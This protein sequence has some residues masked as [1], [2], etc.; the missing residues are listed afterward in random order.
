MIQHK[1]HG[2]VGQTILHY[3]ILEKLGEGGMG[4][5]YRAHDTKLDRDVALKFLPKEVSSDPVEVARFNHEAKAISHLNHDHIATIFN[6]EEIEGQRFIAL[7]HIAGGTLKQRIRKEKLTIEHVIEYSIHITEGLAHAHKHGVIH[8]DLKTDNI[9][10]TEEDE[11]KITD[12][13]LAK[14]KGASK[15]TKT[16]STI[17][18]TAYMSPEQAQGEDVDNRSDL[19][20]LG[21]VLYEIASGTLPFR[22][23]HEMAILYEI[24]NIPHKPLHE[25]D[26]KIPSEFSMIVDKLLEKDIGK[27]YQSAE[28]VLNDLCSLQKPG[29]KNY[30][31]RFIRIKR[32]RKIIRIAVPLLMVAVIFGFVYIMFISNATRGEKKSIAVLPFRNIGDDKE[33][34]YFSDGIT[35]DIINH[36]LKIADLK[37]ISRTSIM[38][39]KNTTK[40]PKQIAA[41]LNVA[42]LLEGSVRKIGNQLR[43]VTNLIDAKT[44]QNKW[45]RTYNKEYAQIFT[46]QSDIAQDV[47]EALAATLTN[48][49]KG[50]MIRQPTQNSEAYR[51]YLEA[52]YLR[53][54]YRGVTDINNSIRLLE[55]SISLDPQNAEAWAELSSCQADL[56]ANGDLNYD[57]CYSRAIESANRALSLDDRCV[58]AH[59]ALGYAKRNYEFDWTG[60]Q[61]EF[62]KAIELEPG[63]A[64]ALLPTSIITSTLGDQERAIDLGKR[65]IDADPLNHAAYIRLAGMFFYAGKFH[66]SY[67]TY[68]RAIE[69]NSSRMFAHFAFSRVLLLQGKLDSAMMEVKKE[70]SPMFHLQGLCLVYSAMR[71]KKEAESSLQSFIHQYEKTDP[72]QIAEIFAYQGN[73]DLAFEWLDRAYERRDSGL[74]LLLDNPLLHKIVN[75]PRYLSLLDKLKLP[76]SKSVK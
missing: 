66:E 22:G 6:I 15:L 33:Q 42:T 67:L 74:A 52:R 37:V 28:E 73:L 30:F 9:M 27:R 56:A 32:Y 13:G 68:H 71:N 39:Y 35:E 70:V 31:S 34:E 54:L 63:N 40:N 12:F 23:E 45:G 49:E 29:T 1:D 72:F 76:H 51:L 47:A 18:T 46:I 53:K 59:L 24:V 36:L 44:E 38:D 26:P 50:R 7:E 20:S 10:L 11:I 2:E 75:D 25:V 69:L 64:L 62:N 60:A 58:A 16:G 57:S 5:V 19:F 21:I 65:A 55:Q 48:D 41:E 61:S 14:L 43:I 3:T 8:R 17:G 4:V